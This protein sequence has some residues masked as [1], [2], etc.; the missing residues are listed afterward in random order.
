MIRRRSGAC[1]R[2]ASVYDSALVRSRA[3]LEAGGRGIP[4]F[5]P[6]IY[7]GVDSGDGRLL[8]RTCCLLLLLIPSITIPPLVSSPNLGT[9]LPLELGSKYHGTVC[10]HGRLM[11][12]SACCR[13]VIFCKVGL[14]WR[15]CGAFRDSAIADRS[16]VL[17]GRSIMRSREKGGGT[18]GQ[19]GREL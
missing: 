2:A 12:V 6:I 4:P 3:A 14:T 11:M 7:G 9:P 1:A 13:I 8:L 10:L 15:P 18:M 16:G 19:M 5:L 17:R